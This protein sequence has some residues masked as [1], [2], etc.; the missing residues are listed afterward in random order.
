MGKSDEKRKLVIKKKVGGIGNVG[1]KELR[2]KLDQMLQKMGRCLDRGGGGH[3]ESH[4]CSN[5]GN[6]L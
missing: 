3:E 2:E 5:P 1:C 4:G 6:A